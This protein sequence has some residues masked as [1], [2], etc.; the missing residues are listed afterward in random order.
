MKTGARVWMSG[1]TMALALAACGSARAA[2]QEKLEISPVQA[3]SAILIEP[4]TGQVL[5][6]QNPD[7]PRSPASI[8]K[9]M[10]ELIV[11]ERVA[12]GEIS[13]TDPVRVSAWASRIGGSQAYLAEN[14]VFMLEDLMKAITIASANDACAA[15]AEHIAGSCEGFV[16]L[17]NLRARQLGLENTHYTNV[18]GL[19]DQPQAGNVTTARDI[20]T[21]ARHLVALPHVLEWSQMIEAPFR[22]GTFTLHNTNKLL[23]RF[24][25]LDGLKTG[26]TR[27]AGFCLCATAERDGMRLV[28]VVMGAHSERE[29]FSESGRLLGSGFAQLR[30][31]VLAAAGKP[32]GQPLPVAGGSPS[33]VSAQ[34]AEALSVLL[35]RGSERPAVKLVPRPALRAPLAAGDTVGTYEALAEDGSAIRVAAITPARVR[36]ATLFERFAAL[37][38]PR[39]D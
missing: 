15:V 16:D 17:M 18:H 25:G 33:T 9:L 39:R 12:S 37:L 35:F 6:A 5:Y 30:R 7:L 23:G 29:R 24:A 36:R 31:E 22:N 3:A 1:I 32:C 28:S 20:A 11:V 10:L 26:Y 4:H 38:R 27:K 2:L 19:D 34:P 13:L 21:I 14:E 8:A